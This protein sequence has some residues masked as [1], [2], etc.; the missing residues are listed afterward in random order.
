MIGAL[1]THLYKM[2]SPFV[3]VKSLDFILDITGKQDRKNVR[4]IFFALKKALYT[5]QSL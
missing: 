2:F 5:I 3:Q 1:K 4:K